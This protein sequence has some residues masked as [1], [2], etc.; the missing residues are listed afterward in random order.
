MAAAPGLRTGLGLPGALAQLGVRGTPAAPTP[1]DARAVNDAGITA[2]H[3][4]W[5]SVA[6]GSESFGTAAG[7]SYLYCS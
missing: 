5:D 2:R 7:D 3:A 6:I 4:Y 1:A